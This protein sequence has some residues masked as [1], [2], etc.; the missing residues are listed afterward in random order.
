M[1]NSVCYDVQ[2]NSTSS[3]FTLH[4]CKLYFL[5]HSH[6]QLR[7]WT[8]LQLLV[9]PDVGVRWTQFH[10]ELTN[11]CFWESRCVKSNQSLGSAK[12]QCYCYCYDYND[13]Y[14]Y[15]INTK[16]S[17][18]SNRDI[19]QTC[20]QSL[21]YSSCFLLH[22][23]EREQNDQAQW[24]LFGYFK[25]PMTHCSQAQFVLSCQMICTPW[26]CYFI[27]VGIKVF[28]GNRCNDCLWF[29]ILKKDGGEIFFSEK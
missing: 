6:K 23:H 22:L 25:C 27:R 8:E 7:K 10:C 9:T 13:D 21:T 12:I 28:P 2:F 20:D 16:C 26:M 14:H 3:C 18:R 15:Y 17:W 5:I 29:V 1:F 4:F 24:L 11:V 19:F